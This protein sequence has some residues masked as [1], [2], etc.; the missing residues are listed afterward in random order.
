MF[1]SFLIFFMH[2]Q[3]NIFSKLFCSYG[4]RS[5]AGYGPWGC[6]QSDITEVTKHAH[7]SLLIETEISFNFLPSKLLF[8]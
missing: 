7:T 3:I 5:L 6:K 1:L 8:Q 2:V 4:Q